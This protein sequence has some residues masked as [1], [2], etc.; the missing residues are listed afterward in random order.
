M[1]LDAEPGP[2]IQLLLHQAACFSRFEAERVAAQV[3]H[4]RAV[5]TVGKQKLVAERS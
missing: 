3:D 5:R 1:G 4:L 2:I